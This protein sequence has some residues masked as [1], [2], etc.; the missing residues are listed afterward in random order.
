MHPHIHI[1]HTTHIH[2]TTAI[3][4]G[5]RLREGE[6]E[7][8]RM[9]AIV[10]MAHEVG[11]MPKTTKCNYEPSLDSVL[12]GQQ[13]LDEKQNKD[14]LT[15][16]QL[17]LYSKKYIDFVLPSFLQNYCQVKKNQN[18]VITCCIHRN[19]YHLN[20]FHQKLQSKR[21]KF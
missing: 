15:H 20:I 1:T 6:R 12:I 3:K 17:Y 8:E 16:R 21:T 11:K 14:Y 10:P 18:F 19:L 2:Y 13:H 4:E 5:G 9:Q 7:R